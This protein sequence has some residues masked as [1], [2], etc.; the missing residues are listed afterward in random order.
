[1]TDDLRT[2]ARRALDDVP[3][4]VGFVRAVL[5]G[6]APGDLWCDRPDDPRAFHVVHPYGMSLVWGP[7]ADEARHE[8]L[9]WLRGRRGSG[10]AEWLQIEPRWSGLDWHTALGA[11]PIEVA[12]PLAPPPATLHTRVNFAFDAA[13]FGPLG[14]SPAHEPGWA[15]RPATA[16]DFQVPGAVVPSAFW[17]DADAFLAN[18]GGMV[19]ERSGEVGAIAFA[20]Y[21]WD[22]N[23]EVGIE[24]VPRFRRRGLARAA[25]AAMIRAVV[26]AGLSPVWSCRGENVGSLRLA[27]SLGFVPTSRTPYFHLRATV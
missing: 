18:G 16:A 7:A 11:V 9:D 5:D 2:A 27:Q 12:D 17:P 24:T 19:I 21:R 23:L 14:P 6:T 3:S 8:V 20:S 1:M 15:T 22:Q 4:N 10:H 26:D 25:A 13:S